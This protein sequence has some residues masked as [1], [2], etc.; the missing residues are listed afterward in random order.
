MREK[1]PAPPNCGLAIIHRG[2]ELPGMRAR[3]MPSG[4]YASGAFQS[5]RRGDQNKSD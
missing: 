2:G 1:A 3:E 5:G 4:D